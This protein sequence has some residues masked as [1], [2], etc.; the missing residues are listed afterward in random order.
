MVFKLAVEEFVRF[1]GRSVIVGGT[2][3]FRFLAKI[4]LLNFLSSQNMYTF[5]K[6]SVL[7]LIENKLSYKY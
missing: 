3:G 4:Y 7:H 6:L 1:G 5:Y 2:P